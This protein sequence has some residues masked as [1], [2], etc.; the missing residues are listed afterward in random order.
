MWNVSGESR[1]STHSGLFS[2]LL[3]IDALLSWGSS[4]LRAPA[5]LQGKG[6][7]AGRQPPASSAAHHPALCLFDIWMDLLLGLLGTEP[8]SLL[9]EP[10]VEHR[11][12][13]CVSVDIERLAQVLVL[14]LISS[15]LLGDAFTSLC[16]IS[17]HIK[18]R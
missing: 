2:E 6:V 8:S 16:F 10:G 12:C 1:P 11:V 3:A 17:S 18:W 14:L 4:V 9:L 5:L 7:C 13:V 15:V